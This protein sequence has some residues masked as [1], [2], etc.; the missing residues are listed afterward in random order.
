MHNLACQNDGYQIPSPHRQQQQAHLTFI[1]F[2]HPSQPQRRSPLTYDRWPLTQATG[3]VASPADNPVN[4]PSVIPACDHW[5]P[6][7]EFVNNG[8]Y[9]SVAWPTMMKVGGSY[10]VGLSRQQTSPFSNMHC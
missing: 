1:H 6:L 2:W 5:A 4:K 9:F 3:A 7:S 10:D 8:T